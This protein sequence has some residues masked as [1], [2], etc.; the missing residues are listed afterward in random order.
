MSR[1]S[2]LHFPNPILKEKS[3]DVVPPFETYQAFAND[4]V[5]TM[6]AFAGCVGLAAPQVGTLLRVIAVDVSRYR[7]PV[8]GHGLHLLFNP[9][10]S[11]ERF[12]LNQREGCLS[13]PDYTGNVPRYQALTVEGFNL[14]G[15]KIRLEVEGFEAVVFQHEIDHLNG[16]LFLDRVSSLKTDVFRRKSFLH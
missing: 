15:E 11:Q 13:V 9:V 5:E 12:L 16:L 10:L 7:K 2:V 1:L 8:K 3:L 14:R 4:F 6:L